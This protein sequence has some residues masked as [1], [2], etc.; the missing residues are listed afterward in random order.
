MGEYTITPSGDAVQGNYTVT[1]QTGKFTIAA[2][3]MS[4]TA[5]T[6]NTLS[7]TGADMSLVTAGSVTGGEMK[8]A[9]GE[10]DT[11][12]PTEY[13]AVVPTGKNVKTYYVWYTAI[14][15]G[16]H[17]ESADVPACVTVN[18]VKADPAVTAPTAADDLIHTGE[19]LVLIK[20]GSTSGGTMKYSLEE[21]GTY[22]TELPTVVELGVYTVWYR[23]DGDENYNDVDP[24]SIQVAVT[25]FN[26]TPPTAIRG[27]IYNSQ[28]HNLIIPGSTDTGIMV[29]SLDGVNYSEDI[30]Q[31][32]EPGVY[33][34]Y[35]K[36]VDE[37]LHIETAPGTVKA[38]ISRLPTPVV[39]SLP[40]GGTTGTPAVPEATT[41]EPE[42]A[43]EDD[44]NLTARLNDSNNIV[45]SW[46][47]LNKAKKYVL[48]AK[49]DD[50]QYVLIT[51]TDKAR[52][53][54]R[55][56]KNNV[57]YHFM[58]KYSDTDTVVSDE[59]KGGTSN[60][61]TTLYVSFS[62]RIKSITRYGSKNRIKWEKI[63]DATKYYVCRVEGDRVI[64]VKKTSKLTALV[65]GTTTTKY[66][67]LARVNNKWTVINRSK[68]KSYTSL[69]KKQ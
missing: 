56:P 65:K 12:A 4:I 58:L 53:V 8:Y 39:P 30:P 41:T 47:K 61:K 43:E 45:V 34:V 29:Y 36:V 16:N 23:V 15:D 26:I 27:L 54:I 9:L 52:V 67:V 60:F 11:T 68:A 31:A 28:K 21:D 24:D 33:T 7:Y 64:G 37:E 2:V 25:D 66:I 19:P 1:Y 59:L 10:N 32:T 38:T 44:V 50:G 48:Y 35:Y 51:T 3:P 22:S 63:N 5:P 20:A 14:P 62:P 42:N 13:D 40:T 55:N 69:K 18:I 6:A 57:S 46:K 49:K 17:I